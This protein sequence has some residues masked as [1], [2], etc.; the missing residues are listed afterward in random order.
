MGLG[1]SGPSATTG[2]TGE[3]LQVVNWV[4]DAWQRIQSSRNWDWLWEAST[5]TIL[6]TTNTTAG[7]IPASRYIKDGC[8]DSNGVEYAYVPWLQFRREYPTALIAAGAPSV[9]TI[10]PDKAFTVNAKPTTNKTFNVERYK[11]PTAMTAD[12]DT[13]ALPTEHHM[14][15]VWR[16]VMLYAGHDEA[17]VLYNHAQAEYR[18]V[19][20]AMGAT[21]SPAVAW[22][23]SW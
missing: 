19:L 7:S 8:T 9:W 10:R 21:D 11:N 15:I 5:V 6:A 16:A 4:D 12:G 14:L 20:S 22:G 13:P 18:K 2:Q 23:V 1:G 17:N 3:M